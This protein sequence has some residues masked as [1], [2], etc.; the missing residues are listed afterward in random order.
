MWCFCLPHRCIIA[1]FGIYH[2]HYLSTQHLIEKVCQ[3][4]L[5]SNRNYVNALAEVK[6]HR[7]G[8]FCKALLLHSSIHKR[9]AIV[10]KRHLYCPVNKYSLMWPSLWNR[11]SSVGQWFKFS[12][13]Y[14]PVVQY[15]LLVSKQVFQVE[16]CIIDQIQYHGSYS[17]G[18]TDQGAWQSFMTSW[19]HRISILHIFNFDTNLSANIW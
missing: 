7:K 3:S 17:R 9:S 16:H 19:L 1:H 5:N 15:A 2:T 4:R 18:D 8:W 12:L 10:S 11:Q 14:W 13:A 6:L